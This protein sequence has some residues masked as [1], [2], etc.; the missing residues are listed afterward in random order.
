MKRLTDDQAV[1]VL[2]L[3]PDRTR[4]KQVE[5][6]LWEHFPTVAPVVRVRMERI[7]GGGVRKAVRTILVAARFGKPQGE[8]KVRK[9]G[10]AR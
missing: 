6:W 7:A 3:V 9:V 2:L 4:L 10:A 1:A 5:R 8:M